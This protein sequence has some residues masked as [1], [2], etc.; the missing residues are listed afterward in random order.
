[1]S[2][3]IMITS[4]KGGVGKSTVCANLAIALANMNKK[5]CCIDLDLGLKNLDIIL[6]LENRLIYD[7]KDV[8]KQRCS[9]DEALI[10]DKKCP[11]LFLL[12]GCKNLNLDK[13][14]LF[15]CEK[16]I[17]ECKKKFD[18]VLIDCPAGI[19]R[20]FQ[21]AL[22]CADEAYIVIQLDITSLMD[23]DRVVGMLLK[24]D[25]N[26]IN[27]IIN[28]V[29]PTYVKNKIQCTIHDATNYL[30]LPCI[31]LIYE[32]CLCTKSVNYGRLSNACSELTTQCFES[33][34]KKT[35]NIDTKIP[36]Y[37]EKSIFKRLINN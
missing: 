25:L 21:Y 18:I 5:V 35:Y 27:V 31:G 28:R 19:E 32:D 26:K 2:R 30:A 3:C 33:I 15:D 34:A 8:I 4:G 10:Q 9:L 6:G 22:A 23:A 13:L 20:G 36:K 12:S 16:I 11:N 37:K 24:N 7:M 1:M 29:N 14:R 17:D